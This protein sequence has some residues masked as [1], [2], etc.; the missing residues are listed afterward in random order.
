[1]ENNIK[2]YV[3]CHK[4]SYVSKNK[5]LYPIQVGAAFAQQRFDNMLHDDEGDN[6]SLKNKSYCELTAQYWVW[7]HEE[8]DY[9]GFFHYRRYFSFNNDALPT[10]IIKNVVFDYIDEETEKKICLDEDIMERIITNEDI[11]VPE[12]YSISDMGYKNVYYQYNTADSQYKKDIDTA[13]TILKEKY[14]EYSS[15]CDEYMKSEKAYICNMFIMKKELFKEY[16][17]W[18]FDILEEVE[19]RSDFSHYSDYGYRVIGFI[20]ERLFGVYVTYLKKQNKYK[21]RELQKTLFLNTDPVANM[22]PISK[23]NNIPVVISCSNLHVTNVSV[24]LKSIEKHSQSGSYYDIIILERDLTIRN[25][26]ILKK[27][28]ENSNITVRFMNVQRFINSNFEETNRTKINEALFSVLTPYL[29]GNYDKA[30]F[31]EGDTI[32]NDDLGKLY[33]TDIENYYLAACKDID[34]IASYNTKENH[35]I[36]YIDEILKIKE[37][38]KFIQTGVMLLNMKK[39]RKD[40]NVNKINLCINENKYINFKKDYINM[41]YQD[42]IKLL[43]MRWNFIVNEDATNLD[44]LRKNVFWN[45]PREIAAEYRTAKMSPS[46]IHYSGSIKP[47]HNPNCECSAYFWNIARQGHAYE[48]LI[49]NMIDNKINHSVVVTSNQSN[50]LLQPSRVSRMLRKVLSEKTV[51]S[52]WRFKNKLIGRG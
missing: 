18:L 7:K 27:S 52:L 28:I 23:N 22:E 20:S 17:S 4:E 34:I 50:I 44:I 45:L 16:S 9:Y 1:M 2:I 31:L 24:L 33:N 48:T 29:L 41:I 39:I 26:E 47:W 36:K 11:I 14:P 25:K 10:D 35:Y 42:A 40:V 12:P 51:M 30:I 38:Y 37:P 19:K 5:F 49:L 46:I 32:V 21:F 43:D 6:I 13:I 3:S 15:S 8:A